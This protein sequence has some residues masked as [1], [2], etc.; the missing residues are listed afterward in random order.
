[1]KRLILGAAILAAAWA[2]PFDV[3]LREYLSARFWL[4]FAKSAASFERPNVRRISA[5]FAGMTRDAADTPLARLRALYQ[6]I[7]SEPKSPAPPSVTDAL[8]AAHATKN[9]AAR[10]REEV[11]LLAAKFELRAAEGGDT[12][13]LDREGMLRAQKMLQTFVRTARTPALHSEARGWLARTY[14]LLGDQTA[15]GKIYLDELNRDGSNLSRDVLL[16]SLR[17]NYGYDGGPQLLARLDEYFDTPEHAAFAIQI[18]TN[19]RWS[20]WEDRAHEPDKNIPA[21]Q[22]V[23]TVLLKHRD[24]LG[25]AAGA[26]RLA[27][28]E[29]RTALG[30][31]DPA[32]ARKIE[33]EVPEDAEVR[34]D[35]DFLWMSAS[36]RYL[37]HDFAAAE[38]PL[39]ALF[40]SRRASKDQKAAAAYGLCGVY[41]KT[42]NVAERLRYSI[43]LYSGTRDH[44]W[45]EP[46]HIGDL[47][48]YWAVSGWD[49]NL[50]VETEAPVEA[51]EAFIR[52]NPD[53]AGLRFIQYSLA[54]RL[55][56]LHRYAE[57]HRIYA[58]IHANRRAPR[59]RDLAKLHS[60]ARLEDPPDAKN[61][62]ARYRLAEFLSQHQNG[63]YYNDAVWFRMQDHAIHP[64]NDIRLTREER[65]EQIAQERELR[66]EQEEYWQAYLILRDVIRDSQ[67]VALR[68]KAAK[69]AV[70]SL[71]RISTRFGRRDEITRADIE[72]SRLLR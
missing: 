21:G 3:S 36:A 35:P 18:A 2:C 9:L 7:G 72:L 27:V 61:L 24:I 48:I 39:K 17:M 14:F 71:R 12:S 1:M 33:E 29:M 28:L 23:K 43:W 46:T 37:S 65:D 54:V 64:A 15:A 6:G 70:D 45:G 20:R 42:R 56:R 68:R 19:P 38:A 40:A 57:A 69:L 26:N 55:T 8:N 31:G 34:E 62:E 66:D 4:P 49:L 50:L 52:E 59:L 58:A 44:G 32:A 25:S 53:A 5:P 63:I 13:V 41:F 47:S 30:A 51:L 11:E 60:A 10:D 22:R 16:T 67:S